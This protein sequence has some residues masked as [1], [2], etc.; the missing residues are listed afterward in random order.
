[1]MPPRGIL[2][3]ARGATRTGPRVDFR[4]LTLPETTDLMGRQTLV[5]DPTVDKIFGVPEVVGDLVDWATGFGQQVFF[6]IKQGWFSSRND[7]D[8]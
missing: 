1:M 7:R 3:R 6:L 8:L 5:P 2:L 4:Q